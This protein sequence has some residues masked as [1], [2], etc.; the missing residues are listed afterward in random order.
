[1]ANNKVPLLDLKAQYAPIRE[2]VRKAVDEVLESQHFILG[3]KVASFEKAVAAYLGT[4]GAVGV[5][6]GSDAIVLALQARDVKAGDEVVT[7][8][9]TFFATAGAVARLGARAV[10]ADISEKTFN[11]DAKAAVAAVTP[12]TKAFLPV[13]LF[14]RC[15]ETEPLVAAG[16]QKGIFV[17]EDAAQSIGAERKGKKAGLLGDGATY[18]FFPSKNL[19][20]VGDGG[21]VAGTD[22]AFLE[23]VRRLRVHGG[24]KTYFHE[25]VGMNSRLDDIQAAVLEVKLKRLDAWTEGRRKNAAA[26]REMLKDVS[27]IV[28]P[29]DDPEGR[30]IYNQ[31][32]ILADRR[33][34][35]KEHLTAEGIG[36]AIYYPLC[37]HQQ[38][39]FENWGYQKGQ[40]PVAERCAERALSIPIYGELTTAQLEQ[41]AGT[42]RG[43]YRG[44]SRKAA[45]S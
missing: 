14:G 44:A 4:P 29:E 45:V 7:T 1:M 18:S 26:Y 17:L 22:L 42:I 15:A 34:A 20:G 35:L 40:F 11:L 13:H 16:K 31:F 36:C 23:R 38:K 27:E 2:E 32:T 3:P 37:L 21:L 8:P 33:D 41:V 39:C 6:N 28:L 9:F 25:E 43:F 30:H 24:A 12:K 19:G 5:A 10:F